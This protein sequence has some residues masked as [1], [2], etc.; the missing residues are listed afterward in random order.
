[1]DQ[2]IL[3]T[4]LPKLDSKWVSVQIRAFRDICELPSHLT[5]KAGIYQIKTNTPVN[6]LLKFG[7]RKD[8]AHYNFEKKIKDSLAL[9]ELTIQEDIRDAY[10]VYTGHHKY[11]RQRCKEHFIGSKGTG[12]LNIFEFKELHKYNWWFEY[13]EVGNFSGF[14]DSKLMRTYLEQLHRANIGWPIL[15][16]Q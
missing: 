2:I 4:L 3:E 15:C 14:N 16:S 10:I 12:C 11:L 6:V 1:M 8:K 9:K 7:I 5:R 13:L